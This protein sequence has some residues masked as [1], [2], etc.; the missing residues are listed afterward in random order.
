MKGRDL[1]FMVGLFCMAFA[2]KI[3][4]RVNSESA[5]L[6]GDFME[7]LGPILLGAKALPKK[8]D[9]QPEPRLPR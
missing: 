6:I 9:S 5:W 3:K 2:G 4:S 1:L 7:T 8:D